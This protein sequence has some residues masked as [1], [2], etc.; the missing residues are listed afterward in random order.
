MEGASLCGQ[1]DDCDDKCVPRICPKPF[2]AARSP[3][4]KERLVYVLENA[5]SF[6]LSI[7]TLELTM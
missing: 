7:I 6:P 1:G 5:L 4:T 3:M 2:L